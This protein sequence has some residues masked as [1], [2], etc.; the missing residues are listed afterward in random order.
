M[1]V[2]KVEVLIYGHSWMVIFLLQPKDGLHGIR[3]SFEWSLFFS[4][5]KNLKKVTLQR[6]LNCPVK[7]LFSVVGKE[8]PTMTATVTAYIQQ[9]GKFVQYHISDTEIKSIK[10]KE[11]AYI[12]LP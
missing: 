10:S 1:V 8:L 6:P 5:L 9:L 3:D 12:Y 7:M 4:T 11:A 2:Y